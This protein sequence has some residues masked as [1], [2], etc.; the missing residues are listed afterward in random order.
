MK[1]ICDLFEELKENHREQNVCGMSEYGMRWD[2]EQGGVK[3]W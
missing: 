3:R 2:A 1:R